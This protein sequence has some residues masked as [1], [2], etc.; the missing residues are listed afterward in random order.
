M[1]AVKVGQITEQNYQIWFD[2]SLIENVTNEIFQPD[3]WQQQGKILGQA[4]GRGTTWFVQTAKLAAALRHYRRGGLFGKL[5][6]DSYLFTGFDNTRAAQEFSLLQYLHSNG[7]PV[8]R[9]IAAQAV[10]S[11]VTYRADILVEKINDAQD[12]V[13]VLKQASLTEQDYRQ[14]GA[15][16]N[17]MHQLQVCHTDLNIHNILQDKQGKFWLIDFDKCGKQTGDGWKQANLERLLR[18]FNKELLRENI[19]WQQ[20]EWQYLLQGYHQ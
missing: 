10:R 4:K 18:S 8:P 7:V 6:K 9:P 16:V 5:V 15:L 17:N 1:G 2:Q 13:A 20:Q 12:L 3:Y 14:I 11:G 19:R